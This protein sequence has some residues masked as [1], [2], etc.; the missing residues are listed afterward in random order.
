MAPRDSTLV[1]ILKA[2][3]SS[4]VEAL[5]IFLPVVLF[6][7]AVPVWLGMSRT[8]PV[9]AAVWFVIAMSFLTVSQWGLHIIGLKH[10]VAGTPLHAL[11]TAHW[12]VPLWF[13]LDIAVFVI[14]F[15]VIY[16]IAAA[17]SAR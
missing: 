15:F 8:N 2:S 4:P 11:K 17:L 14:P 13:A 9:F 12:F 10:N 1:A 16:V 3:W 5:V 6:V 7:G